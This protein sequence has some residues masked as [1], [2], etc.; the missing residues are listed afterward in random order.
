MTTNQ[1]IICIVFTVA[2]FSVLAWRLKIRIDGRRQITKRR[3]EMTREQN[4]D[5]FYV[6]VILILTFM[7]VCQGCGGPMTPREQWLFGG[8]IASQAA[9]G[10]TTDTYISMG[11]TELNPMLGNRPDTEAIA[12]LKIGTVLTL[13]GL[14]EVWPEHREAI[15]TVGIISGG[16]AAGWNTH[17]IEKHK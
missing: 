3:R 8:M 13:W 7:V 1:L 6:I 4:K 10:W 15:F 2:F 12:L 17:L 14:G 16:V 9:D 11:G 5:I